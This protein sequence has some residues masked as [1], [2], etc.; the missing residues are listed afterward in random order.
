[1]SFWKQVSARWG[2][3]AADNTISLYQ[4][5]MEYKN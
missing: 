2:S 3:A 4:A 5:I 1:M